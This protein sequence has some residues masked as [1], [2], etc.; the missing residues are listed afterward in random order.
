[1]ACR[2]S[3]TMNL[4]LRHIDATDAG[5]YRLARACRTPR[6]DHAAGDPTWRWLRWRGAR[7]AKAWR[8]APRPCRQS[9]SA[10]CGSSFP[11][12]RRRPTCVPCAPFATCASSDHG[13]RLA[14]VKVAA[15]AV[16]SATSMRCCGYRHRRGC[17]QLA[18]RHRPAAP[19]RLLRYQRRRQAPGPDAPE[20]ARAFERPKVK[21]IGAGE[22]GSIRSPGYRPHL[23]GR[24]NSVKPRSKK[25]R[26]SERHEVR[27][28]LRQLHRRRGPAMQLETSDL[29]ERT[30]RTS[31]PTANLVS[32]V[33]TPSTR[34][35]A[36]SPTTTRQP[37]GMTR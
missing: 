36:A 22:A 12:R 1:M 19:P 4:K 27:L 3:T 35:A 6:R 37:G 28:D 15:S 34:T 29:R 32:G 5:G 23:H 10:T 2:S 11:T 30:G 31:S 20:I 14:W 7:A 9:Q 33:G 16:L 21:L 26:R 25:Q 24:R 13:E 18:D 17:R 8:R